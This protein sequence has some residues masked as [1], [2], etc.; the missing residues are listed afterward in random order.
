METHPLHETRSPGT[1]DFSLNELN[2]DANSQVLPV[3][4]DIIEEPLAF[5]TEAGLRE[6]T[7]LLGLL[8]SK[9]AV[10]AMP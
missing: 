6:T 7:A 2:A 3:A 10:L 1:A 4:I 8:N 9:K 5:G